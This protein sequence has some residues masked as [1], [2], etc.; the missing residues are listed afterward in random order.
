M[1]GKGVTNIYREEGRD[2]GH[3]FTSARTLSDYLQE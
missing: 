3:V 2:M 1:M